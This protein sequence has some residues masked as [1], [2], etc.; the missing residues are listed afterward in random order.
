M[1]AGLSQLRGASFSV[2]SHEG[3]EMDVNYPECDNWDHFVRLPPLGSL[4]ALTE[5]CLVGLAQLPPDFSQ[6]HHLRYLFVD[7]EHDREEDELCEWGA[8]PLTGLAS[9]THVEVAS[10]AHEWPGN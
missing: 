3:S 6:L 4:T 1:L 10:F 5:L 7:C 8:E 9:L 2:H